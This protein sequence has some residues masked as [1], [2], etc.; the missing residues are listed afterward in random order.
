MHSLVASSLESSARTGITSCAAPVKARLA[1]PRLAAVHTHRHSL[2]AA[3]ASIE[4]FETEPSISNHGDVFPITAIE[5][6][7]NLDMGLVRANSGVPRVKGRMLDAV[8]D[9]FICPCC[10]FCS[11]ACGRRL[12]TR[13]VP[14]LQHN[15]PSGA[16]E[17][18]RRDL[19]RQL[20]AWWDA[21]AYYPRHAS[22]NDEGGTV[23][24]HLV[25]LPDGRI[26]T[27][28]VVES[29]G[30]RSLDTAGVSVF[31]GGSCDRFRR[32]SR[33]PI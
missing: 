18:R 25:I 31:R 5:C 28:D 30:S 8:V 1:S 23:K 10:S 9:R 16:G 33:T 20:Q 2:A 15:E 26:W 17:R 22:N 24:V 21:H 27:I 29:S 13:V 7:K 32:A 19:M 12:R 4:P 14:G 3:S 11:D 6:R